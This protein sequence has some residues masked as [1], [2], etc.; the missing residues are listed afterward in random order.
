MARRLIASGSPYEEAFAYSRAVVQGDFCF[1][2]GTVGRNR[3]TGDMPEGVEAQTENAL[4]TI[5]FALEQAGF[6][7]K[8]VVRH[9][10]YLPDPEDHP[11]IAAALKKAF[12]DVRPANTTI[13]AALLRPEWKIEIEVTAYRGK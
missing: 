6:S 1:V 11:K 8:D 9:V 2:A 3:L 7:L 5:S 12:G 4:E 10:I 13:C